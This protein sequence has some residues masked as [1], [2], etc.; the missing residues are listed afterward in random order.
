MAKRMIAISE[1]YALEVGSPTPITSERKCEEY[2]MLLD[3]LTSKEKP[4]SDEETYTEA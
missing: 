1:K 2:L 3:R 4:S